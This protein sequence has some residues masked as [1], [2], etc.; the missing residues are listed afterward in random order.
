MSGS[1]N[2]RACVLDQP[3]ASEHAYT[4]V[5]AE[6]DDELKELPAGVRRF[7]DIKA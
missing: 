5:P 1:E 6:G 3:L 7:Q 4:D 2:A